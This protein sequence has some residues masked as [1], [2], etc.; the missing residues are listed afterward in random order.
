MRIEGLPDAAQVLLVID[1]EK[2]NTFGVT[3]S[4]INNTITANL[5]SS[6]IN[7]FPNAGR[8]PARHSCRRRIETA[9][10]SKTC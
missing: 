6:Y 5:G 8:M 3:F 10:R 7:D 4:D 9:F 1:R 2:A